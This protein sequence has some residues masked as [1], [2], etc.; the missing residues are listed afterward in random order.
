MAH[1]EPDVRMRYG[2][3]IQGQGMAVFQKCVGTGSLAHMD[4]N[5]FTVRLCQ[6]IDRLISGVADINGAVARIEL[7]ACA[8]IPLQMLFYHIVGV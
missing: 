3:L 7:D 8:G 5:R 1:D 2:H 4:G 6:L